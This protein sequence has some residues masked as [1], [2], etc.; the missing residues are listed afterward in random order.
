MPVAVLDSSE[1][2]PFSPALSCKFSTR[3][4]FHKTMKLEII[5]FV[6]LSLLDTAL[7]RDHSHTIK[8]TLVKCTIQCFFRTF[9]DLC[10]YDH[11]L[12][13]VYFHH[14]PKKLHAQ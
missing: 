4:L 2:S 13:V 5:W 10:N 14:P 9:T 1:F 6:L 8:F 7:W 12:I 3:Q 11:Y